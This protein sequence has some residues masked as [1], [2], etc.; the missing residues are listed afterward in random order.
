MYLITFQR[1]FY[2]TWFVRQI[3]FLSDFVNSLYSFFSFSEIASLEDKRSENGGHM[4]QVRRVFKDHDQSMRPAGTKPSLP[5][6]LAHLQ[7][8]GTPVMLLDWTWVHPARGQYF[9]EHMEPRAENNGSLWRWWTGLRP[10]YFLDSRTPGQTE[11][12]L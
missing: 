4:A 1:S 11:D 12:C 8:R 6:K 7:T 9:T 5:A 10:H 2:N 3:I